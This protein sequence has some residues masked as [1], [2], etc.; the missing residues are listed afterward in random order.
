MSGKRGSK[1]RKLIKY[2]ILS[3]NQYN[4]TKFTLDFNLK[5]KIY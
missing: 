1:E 5:I 4:Y 2:M 3:K